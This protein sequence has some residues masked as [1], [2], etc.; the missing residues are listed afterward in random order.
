M[1]EARSNLLK[2][3]ERGQHESIVF[4]HSNCVVS[5]NVESNTCKS[6]VDSSAACVDRCGYQSLSDNSVVDCIFIIVN[7][8]IK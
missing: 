2:L 3:L 8:V 7:A 1:F 4:K 5:L 6:G